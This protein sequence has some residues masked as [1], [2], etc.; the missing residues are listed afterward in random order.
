[1][2]VGLVTLAPLVT[3]ARV[4]TEPQDQRSVEPKLF[5]RIGVTFELAHV[6][7]RV[8]FR[9]DELTCFTHEGVR[10]PRRLVVKGEIHQPLQVRLFPRLVHE[11]I[12]GRIRWVAAKVVT[13]CA[14]LVAAPGAP[15][16]VASVNGPP[17]LA[18]PPGVTRLVGPAPSELGGVSSLPFP[19]AVAVGGRETDT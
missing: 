8:A 2:S 11:D 15:R 16:P 13:D 4:H 14:E 18:L 19:F 1:M 10:C 3:E 7:E 6:L 17:A 9:A 12:G 5:A